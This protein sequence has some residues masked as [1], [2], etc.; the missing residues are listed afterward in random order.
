[1]ACN[2]LALVPTPDYEIAS[3]GDG[4]AGVE[5]RMG[6]ERERKPGRG[7]EFWAGSSRGS[8]DERTVF[9]LIH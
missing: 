8:G 6:G 2:L 7:D 5:I 3:A 4:G 1:M 9:S